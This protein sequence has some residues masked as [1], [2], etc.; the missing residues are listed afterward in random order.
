MA[1]KPLVFNQTVNI[2]DTIEIFYTSPPSGQGTRVKAFAASNN[3]ESSRSYKAYIYD[4]TGSTVLAII[5]FTIV[6]RDKVN[7]GS[8][9]INQ[10]IPA[11]GTLRIE[12]S[13]TDGPNFYV[14]GLEL[15]S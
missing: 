9:I 14:T 11:G 2:A 10:V 7:F 1:D 3:T 5:P 8:S 4:S 13:G 6:V 12:A 15:S